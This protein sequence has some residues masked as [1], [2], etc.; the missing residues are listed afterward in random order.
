MPK[1]F[2]HVFLKLFQIGIKGKGLKL[3]MSS[4][5]DL[6]SY[7]LVSGAKSDCFAVKQ[8]ARRGGV[9]STWFY[10]LFIDGLRQNLQESGTGYTI[11]SLKVGNPTLADD[12]TLVCP[13]IKTFE[14]ALSI[15]YK[16][17][18]KWRFSFN[19]ARCHLSIFSLQRSPSNVSV[20]FG[21]AKV[22]RIQS[23]AHV[24]IEL[25]ESFKSSCAVELEFKKAERP[26]FQSYQ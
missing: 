20:R 2:D 16:Y 21:S 13:T 14:K 3:I 7:V 23:V 22:S 10:W 17:S 1:V 18:T 24:G 5:K 26:C 9:T 12:L 25:L 8:G 11:E 4:Y 19:P 6:S 15:V